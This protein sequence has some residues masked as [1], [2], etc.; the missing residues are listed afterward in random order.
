M[1]QVPFAKPD[2]YIRCPACGEGEYRVDHLPVGCKTRWY[3]DDANC[4]AEYSV[5]VL[6]SDQIE[7]VPTGGRKRNT[8]VTLRCE[9]PFTMTVSGIRL[10]PDPADPDGMMEW[11]DFQRFH[12]EENSCPT[13]AFTDVVEIF[14]AGGRA[15]P[16]GLLKFVKVEIDDAN[17]NEDR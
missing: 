13:N 5:Y 16:H 14:D 10:E 4:G 2:K 3:C 1:I 8:T 11:E 6:A 12:Y 9:D 7:C 15:D 17:R